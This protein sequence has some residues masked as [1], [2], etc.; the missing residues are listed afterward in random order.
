MWVSLRSSHPATV[1]AA[2]AGTTG[3]SSDSNF[4][5]R[6]GVIVREGGRSSIPE[7]PEFKLRGC[8]VLDARLR[9]HDGSEG[10]D[11]A[12]SRHDVPELCVSFHPP[13]RLR[14]QGK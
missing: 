14:A 5:Q 12:L 11:S 2:K 3:E 1:V 4:K 8:R 7:T 13:R 6:S 10:Y 9:G